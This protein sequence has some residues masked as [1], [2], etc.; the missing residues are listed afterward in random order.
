MK[1]NLDNYLLFSH[2]DNFL[3]IHY[4]NLCIYILIYFQY[5]QILYPHDYQKFQNQQYL[6]KHK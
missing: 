5:M 4:Q 1:R 6:T 2:L 3:S